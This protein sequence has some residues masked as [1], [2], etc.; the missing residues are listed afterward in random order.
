MIFTILQVN[1]PVY[2]LGTKICGN[3]CERSKALHAPSIL[4]KCNWLLYFSTA[5]EDN[6]V[7]SQ[8]VC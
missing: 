8:S 6:T 4:S 2:K 7:S 3:K 1:T 5:W